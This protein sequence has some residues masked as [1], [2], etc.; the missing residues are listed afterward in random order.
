MIYRFSLILRS[1]LSI[2]IFMWINISNVYAE[3]QHYGNFPAES[4]ADRMERMNELGKETGQSVSY[5]MSELENKRTP[6][7]TPTTNN[8]EEWLHKSLENTEYTYEKKSNNRYLVVKVKK[9]VLPQSKQI[10]QTRE[11]RGTVVDAQ[12]APLI[13]VNVVQKG[14]SNGTVTDVDGNFSFH[15]TPNSTIVFTY[16]GFTEQE[17]VWDGRSR[18][19]ITLSED[20]ELLDE[21][22]V[23]G[24]GSVKKRDLTGSVSSLSGTLLRDLPVAS[25][26]E[27]LT[28][29]LAGV[30]VS[31]TEGDPNAE[32]KIRIRGG[33][34]ITQDNSPLY[35]VDGFPVDNMN[36]IPTTDIASI[37]ILKDAS[38]SAIYGAR[39]ANGVVLITTKRGAEGKVKVSFNS[40]YGVKNITKTLDVLNPYEYVYWQY[41]L[42]GNNDTFRKY[43]G[44]FRDYDLYK[45]MEG[46][47]WQDEVF[48]R[49]GTSFSNNLTLS[50]GNKANQY[51]ISLNRRDEKEIMIGSAY[52]RMNFNLNTSHQVKDWLKLDLNVRLSDYY[53]KGAGTSSNTRLSH[54]VQFR[55]VNG[56]VNYIDT[57]LD[58]NDYEVISSNILDPVKQILDDYRRRKDLKFNFNGAANINFTS[59]L[60]YRFEYGT[61]YGTYTDKRFYGVNTSNAFRYGRLP[62]ASIDNRNSNSYRVANILT[63][64]KDNILPEH[65]M[66]LMVGQELNYEKYESVF[67]TSKFFPKT[68]DP[69]GALAMMSLGI[70]DPTD[71]FDSPASKLSSYFGRVNY[72]MKDRYLFSASYRMD[73]SSKFAPE[74]RWASFP[75]AAFAWRMSSEDFMSPTEKWLD[76]L[77]LRLSYGASGNNR[78]P[79]NAWKKIYTVDAGGLYIDGDGEGS[80]P[81]AYF[82]PGSVLSNPHLKWETTITRN[83]GL[84]FTMFN[85]RL[86]GTIEAYLN[87]T[88]DLLLSA[89]IPSNTGYSRQWQNIGQTSNRGIELTLNGYI[90][91]TKDFKLFSSFNIG[92]N[93]NRIDKLGDTKRWE[94]NT[95]WF[96]SN[97]GPSGEYLIEEGGQVGV[98]YGF[99]TEGMYTFDDFTYDNGKYTLKEGVS[100]N[101]SLTMP[102]RFWPGALKLKDQNGDF[103]VDAANDKVVI[104][105][106]NPKNSGGFSFTS[107]FRGFDMS[108]FFNW[109]YGNDIYNANKLYFHMYATGY[110]YKNILDIANSDHRFTYIDKLTGL[111]VSDPVKLAEMNQHATLWSTAM[112][113]AALH[114]WVI[115]DG[116]FLRLNNLTLGYTLPKPLLANIGIESLR[117][118]F[119][120][121]NLWLWTSYTG[122]DPEVDTRRATPLTPGIDWN[123]YPRSRS[124]NMGINLEF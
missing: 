39:G 99:E 35:V 10:E 80:A 122:Y 61:Q 114:S 17:V 62:Y 113:H 46:T 102:R 64:N 41:E 59:D 81:T 96:T 27:S 45:Q 65:N 90:V 51:N 57:D 84:D 9:E 8:M 93:K 67:N 91:D 55:P 72:D 69:E 4:L 112:T 86:N 36:D 104:G 58:D 24:Y 43:Y 110:N 71:T 124:F 12:H 95:D 14:T 33:G 92:V 117:V 34:S 30:Q 68:I 98:I 89:S 48:G 44:D 38:S 78:I 76:D 54:A 103:V 60:L 1:M 109:V 11:V 49:N 52:T 94:Q 87:T 63:Y 28:G 20:T 85:Q 13:G 111:E 120:G 123:A 56:V 66:V 15:V 16:I 107:Q 31:K 5:N 26:A 29:R 118:Y 82:K 50:G 83:M 25:T 75:S 101:S 100:D 19:S 32:V 18:L 37:D 74:N 6:A 116:S 42:Q 53:L 108:A 40:Y 106:T 22:V 121:Y 79:D 119:T 2:Y 47:N 105:N 77:K 23:I 70:P 3:M 21:V 115:E 7:L 88:K 73:G 97:S